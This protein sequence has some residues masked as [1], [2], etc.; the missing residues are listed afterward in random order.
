MNL[1]KL[2]GG[3]RRG[4]LTPGELFGWFTEL[5]S[6]DPRQLPLA[7]ASLDF[8]PKVRREFS[9][10]LEHLQERPEILHHGAK[11]TPSQA[12][13]EVLAAPIV[14]PPRAT[15]AIP[16][17][18]AIA[19]LKLVAPMI[20]AIERRFFAEARLDSD[21]VLDRVWSVALEPIVASIQSGKLLLGA[22]MEL[23]SKDAP[24]LKLGERIQ[25]SLSSRPLASGLIV[26][27]NV[28]ADDLPV[29]EDFLA[30]EAA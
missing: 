23:L 16:N 30:P 11:L 12:L 14:A 19:D 15:Q 29:D 21:S 22:A 17:H 18:L 6:E 5:L 24:A 20:P 26:Q 10:W 2:V 28:G 25:L 4:L 27:S 9:A 8:E 13:L 3:Y 1:E 7:L